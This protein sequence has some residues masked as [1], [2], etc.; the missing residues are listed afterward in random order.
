MARNYFSNFLKKVGKQASGAIRTARDQF[1]TYI[2]NIVDP[3]DAAAR[4]SFLKAFEK[5]ADDELQ[6]PTSFAQFSAKYSDRLS[7]RLEAKHLGRLVMFYYSAKHQE[8]LPYWDR[9]PL[10]L[11]TAIHR[12]RVIGLNLHYLPPA[13]RAQ[14]LDS[15]VDNEIKNKYKEEDRIRFSYNIMRRAAK[16]RNFQPCV[17]E[18]IQNSKFVKSRFLVI[19]PDEWERVLFLPFERFASKTRKNVTKESVWRESM[20]SKNR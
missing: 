6:Q 10:I 11:V 18:Y 14:L 12:D 20:R 17:K 2:D 16:N 5:Q 15:I 19:P 8:T 4:D 9:L 1:L 7:P 3:R 13:Q